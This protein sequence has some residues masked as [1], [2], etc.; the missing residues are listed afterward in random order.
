MSEVNLMINETERRGLENRKQFLEMFPNDTSQ[1]NDNERY[2]NRR[3]N[4][5]YSK[6]NTNMDGVRALEED[7]L[8]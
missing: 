1:Y 6:M 3:L 2:E 4:E 5:Y 7:S 8:D